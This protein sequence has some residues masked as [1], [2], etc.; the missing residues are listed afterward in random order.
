MW[1][2]EKNLHIKLA[3]KQMLKTVLQNTRHQCIDP[4]HNTAKTIKGSHG[5]RDGEMSLNTSQFCSGVI[6]SLPF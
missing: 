4:K 2:L 6:L 5:E 3:E 1:D